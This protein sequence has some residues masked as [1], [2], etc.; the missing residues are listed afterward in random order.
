MYNSV[1][2]IGR[3]GS[4]IK[5]F[6]TNSDGVQGASFRLAT[7]KKWKKGEE[8][9]QETQWHS[10]ACFGMAANEIESRVSKGDLVLVTGEI[11]YREITNKDGQKVNITEI[12]GSVKRIAKNEKE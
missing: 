12:S 6:S 1:T 2:L 8:W 9:Q 3:I 4:D 11:R 5:T 7:N 10:I